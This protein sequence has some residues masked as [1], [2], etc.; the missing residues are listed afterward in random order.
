[1]QFFSCCSTDLLRHRTHRERKEI[2]IKALEEQVMRLK[3][4]FTGTIQEKNA[5]AE[6]NRKLKELLRMHGINDVSVDGNSNSGGAPST[7]GG[8]V[9]DSRAGSY[10]FNPS[11]TPSP[12][13]FSG[14]GSP[15]MSQAVRGVGQQY[16]GGS[17]QLQQQQQRQ[18]QHNNGLDHDQIGVDFV[19]ASVDPRQG[20]SRY[21]PPSS[22]NYYSRTQ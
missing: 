2:Y 1:M 3:E 5:I 9:T 6:E 16:L 4:N 12:S 19:L 17:P 20:T 18:Q 13:A 10:N 7:Y 21:L 11:F 15:G 8:S 22:H 14:D